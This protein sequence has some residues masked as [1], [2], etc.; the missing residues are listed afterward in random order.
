MFPR[1]GLVVHLQT[2]LLRGR[3]SHLIEVVERREDGLQ[4][5]GG[6][7]QEETVAGCLGDDV[8]DLPVGRVLPVLVSVGL[9]DE[10]VVE[11]HDRHDVDTLE[12]VPP[13]AGVLHGVSHLLYPAT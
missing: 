4:V 11:R 1:T 13:R 2:C 10:L 8:Q 9:T 5:G 7:F 12:H 3:I 6:E